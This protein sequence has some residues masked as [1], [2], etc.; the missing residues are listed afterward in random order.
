V[1]SVRLAQSTSICSLSP[2]SDADENDAALQPAL[3]LSQPAM[4]QALTRC[5]TLLKDDLIIRSPKG[6]AP[7][8]LSSFQ[9]HQSRMPRISLINRRPCFGGRRAGTG[10]T[11][12]EA[13]RGGA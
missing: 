9:F 1:A 13:T 6:H 3:G 5:A 7:P 11:G 10:G 2:R 8:R 4:S 12:R